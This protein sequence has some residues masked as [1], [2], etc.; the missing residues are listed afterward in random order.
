VGAAGILEQGHQGL[1]FN[2]Y[3]R[4]PKRL[5]QQALDDE[6]SAIATGLMPG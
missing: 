3:R 4:I 6:E 2:K 1:R 5:P